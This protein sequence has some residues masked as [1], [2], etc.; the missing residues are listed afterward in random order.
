MDAAQESVSDSPSL[1]ASNLNLT[2]LQ[3]Q[4]QMQNNPF[5]ALFSQQQ[6]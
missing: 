1:S 4:Q 2:V 6:G 5:S 3:I